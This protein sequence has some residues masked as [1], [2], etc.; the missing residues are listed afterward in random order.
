MKRRN[1]KDL[2]R[3]VAQA[4]KVRQDENSSGMYIS[5]RGEFVRATLERG[6]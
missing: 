2:K 6:N 1:E 5:C 4:R 3:R